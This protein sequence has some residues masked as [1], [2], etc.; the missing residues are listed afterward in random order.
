MGGDRGGRHRGD[1]DDGGATGFMAAAY[2][3]AGTAYSVGARISAAFVKI[4]T[5]GAM[6]QMLNKFRL[7]FDR[8]TKVFMPSSWY[9]DNDGIK[10]MIPGPLLPR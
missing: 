9:S 7:N 2:G 4:A 1:R 6:N 10:R 8:N 3:V 5:V